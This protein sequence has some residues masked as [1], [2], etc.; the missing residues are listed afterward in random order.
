MHLDSP[1]KINSNYFY[2]RQLI[3]FSNLRL[4]QKKKSIF[5]AICN[6]ELKYKYKPDKEWNIEGFLCAYCHMEKTKEFISIQQQQIPEM[7]IVCKKQLESEAEKKKPRWQWDMDSGSLLCNDC[8]EK[9]EL[10]Y[11]KKHNYCS[12][13][14]QRIGFI[15][16]NPKPKWKIDGQLCKHCWDKT[17]QNER[18][19]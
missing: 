10:N 5:C 3:S 2:L 19:W 6:K 9:Q 12:I 11:E 18:Q 13:C 16:Y 17:N 15:R 7:C 14:N 8:F 4:F 1:C